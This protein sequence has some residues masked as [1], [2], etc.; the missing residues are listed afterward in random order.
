VKVQICIKQINERLHSCC[1]NGIHLNIASFNVL[2]ILLVKILK[3]WNEIFL[4][5]NIVINSD[6]LIEHSGIH[7]KI[8]VIDGL[9]AVPNLDLTG[10]RYFVFF[11]IDLDLLN[12]WKKHSSHV[13]LLINYNS[14]KVVIDRD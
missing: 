11:A 7:G 9:L 8:N 13:L 2:G 14:L 4:P 5:C 6:I 1:V 10:I 12:L 3:L